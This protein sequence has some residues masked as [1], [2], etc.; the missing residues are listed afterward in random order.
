MGYGGMHSTFPTHAGLSP[1]KKFHA[2]QNIKEGQAIDHEDASD[3]D[4]DLA[5]RE[6]EIGQWVDAKDTTNKWLCAQVVKMTASKVWVHF[7]GWAD[8]WNTWLDKASQFIAPLGRYTAK[9]AHKVRQ[10]KR[11]GKE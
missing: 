5:E 9:G 8:K 1:R 6:F 7:D 2:L 4:V 11:K 10:N 3:S